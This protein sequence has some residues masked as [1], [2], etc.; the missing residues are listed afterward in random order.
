MP[1]AVVLKQRLQPD[2]QRPFDSAPRRDANPEITL[3]NLPLPA[4]LRSLSR[5]ESHCALL[6]LP[7]LPADPEELPHVLL[8][9]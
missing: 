8:E 2:L 4:F 6:Q 7:L 5:A 3:H 9:Y 1:Q